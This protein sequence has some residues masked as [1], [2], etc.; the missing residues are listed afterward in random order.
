MAVATEQ[1]QYHRENNENDPI[2]WGETGDV[3]GQRRHRPMI[4]LPLAGAM[5]YMNY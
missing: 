3:G 1:P 5:L 4:A 2:H